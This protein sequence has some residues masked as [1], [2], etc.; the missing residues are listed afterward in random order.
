MI[1]LE[2]SFGFSVLQQGY[3]L[4]QQGYSG[5]IFVAREAEHQALSNSKV[6]M[7]QI[8]DCLSTFCKIVKCL[9]IMQAFPPIFFNRDCYL[10]QNMINAMKNTICVFL[11]CLQNNDKKNVCI[12]L[13]QMK[14]WESLHQIYLWSLCGYIVELVTKDTKKQL[15]FV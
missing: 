6:T 5:Y 2:Y 9:H 11:H 4:L 15:I 14:P 10:T 7:P 3:I 1:C 12:C 13:P 8:Q